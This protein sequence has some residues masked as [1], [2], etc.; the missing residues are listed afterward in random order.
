MSSGTTPRSSPPVD[1]ARGQPKRF[2][3]FSNGFA[4]F[5]FNLWNTKK[6]GTYVQNLIRGTLK[7]SVA[8][9]L[10]LKGDLE[11]TDTAPDCQRSMKQL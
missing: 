3:S 6:S 10:N 7:C 4:F 1:L 11:E 9:V 8:K 2:H 5:A